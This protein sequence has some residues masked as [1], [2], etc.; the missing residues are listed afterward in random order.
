MRECLICQKQRDN[1]NDGIIYDYCNR[2]LAEDIAVLQKRY[3]K[4]EASRTPAKESQEAN[5]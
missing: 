4:K 5:K 1:G 3:E 2:C